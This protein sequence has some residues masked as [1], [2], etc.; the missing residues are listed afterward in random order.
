MDSYEITFSCHG[1]FLYFSYTV[2][3]TNEEVTRRDWEKEEL[4][5]A[6]HYAN[7][8]TVTILWTLALLPLSTN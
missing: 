2:N 6:C 4:L 8:A 7:N 5:A 1:D 3:V